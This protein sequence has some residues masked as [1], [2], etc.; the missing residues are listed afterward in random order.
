[1]DALPLVINRHQLELM[2]E[3]MGQAIAQLQDQAEQFASADEQNLST[4]GTKDYSEAHTLV[5]GIDD[6]IQGCLVSWEDA[7]DQ[8]KPVNISLNTYQIG[9]LRHSLH[10][11]MSQRTTG[12]GSAKALYDDILGQLPEDSPQEDAD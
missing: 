5:K 6:E 12:N 7:P 4:Y 10:Q 2:H 11:G 3:D 8:P 1:M 9:I